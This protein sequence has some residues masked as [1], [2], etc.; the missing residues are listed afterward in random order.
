MQ[1]RAI[2]S[3]DYDWLL[4]L[5]HTVYRELIIEEFGYWDDDEELGLFLEAWETKKIEVIMMQGEP[6]ERV[7]VGVEGGEFSYRYR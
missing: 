7:H 2:Q 5:H 3:S 1:I 4:D 6:V